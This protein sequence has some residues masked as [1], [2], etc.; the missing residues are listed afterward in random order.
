[1]TRLSIWL[2]GLFGLAVFFFA[3]GI[4]CASAAMNHGAGS[5]SDYCRSHC[6]P[7]ATQSARNSCESGCL[8][9]RASGKWWSGCV[10]VGADGCASAGPQ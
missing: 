5:L 10:T 4:H 8:Q 3:G 7:I 2:T 6:A 1:M 9:H